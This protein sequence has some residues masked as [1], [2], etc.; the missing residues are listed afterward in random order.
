MLFFSGAGII[1]LIVVGIYLGR[2]IRFNSWDVLHPVSFLKKLKAHFSKR[3]SV[4]D[5]ILYVVINTVFFLI[6]YVSF[7]IPFYFMK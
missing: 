7:G 4:K 1:L 6:M 5:F 3:G 2:T